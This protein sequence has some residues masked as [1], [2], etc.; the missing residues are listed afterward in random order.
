MFDFKGLLKIIQ[1]KTR[2]DEIKTSLAHTEPKINSELPKNL[3]DT[4]DLVKGLT[5][6]QAIKFILWNGLWNQYGIFG[7]KREEARIFKE[8]DK[9]GNL[10]EKDYYSKRY[11]RG[12]LLSIDFGVSNIGRELSYVHTGIVIDD[13]PSIVVVVP[14]TSKK[15]SGLNNISDEI[16]K[17]II[18]VLKKDYPEIKEDSYILTH[19]IRAVSKNRIT[20]IVGS[21][22]RTKLM[23]ELEEMLF[24]RQTPYIKKLKNEQ[25]EALE[26]RISDLEKQLQSLTKPQLTN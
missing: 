8:K 2:R 6:E 4:E 21:I 22:A 11:G 16:K 20:K 18:P 7:D 3:K 10:V 9:E 19:Q 17:C 15:D 23:E 14:M 1:D 5:I 26:K 25:I 13:Y 24:S 12:K